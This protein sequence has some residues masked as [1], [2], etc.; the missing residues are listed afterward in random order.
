MMEKKCLKQIM[1][2]F[3][4]A[5]IYTCYALVAV[6]VAYISMVFW[7]MGFIL[8]LTRLDVVPHLSFSIVFIVS[9]LGIYILIYYSTYKIFVT[10]HKTILKEIKV[11][12]QKKGIRRK[13]QIRWAFPS[14]CFKCREY[15]SFISHS[16]SSYS[17][18]C[19]ACILKDTKKD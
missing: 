10:I 11:N 13:Y 8:V 3:I 5:L 14:M 17:G 2:K 7:V 6:A 18:W 16:D 1:K 9:L 15:K 12:K 19:I 4:E